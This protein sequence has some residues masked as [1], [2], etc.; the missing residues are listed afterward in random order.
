[1]ETFGR[2]E[3]ANDDRQTLKLTYKLKYRTPT[4]FKSLC[5]WLCGCSTALDNPFK[6][7]ETN[8]M[9]G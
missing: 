5:Y 2:T 3:I 9:N 6:Q 4:F 7:Y 1:M 8:E